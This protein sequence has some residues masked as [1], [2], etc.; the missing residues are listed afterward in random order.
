ML[1][2]HHSGSRETRTSRRTTQSTIFKGAIRYT[3]TSKR[4]SYFIWT[5]PTPA[6]PR[7]AS[8]ELLLPRPLVVVAPSSQLRARARTALRSTIM[9]STPAPAAPRGKTRVRHSPVDVMDPLEL[10]RRALSR[11][12]HDWSSA[13]RN[14]VEGP[15]RQPRFEAPSPVS[16]SSH[17]PVPST[18]PGTTSSSS[19]CS[20]SSKWVGRPRGPG[21]PRRQLSSSTR[22]TGSPHSRG[23]RLSTEEPLP[24]ESVLLSPAAAAQLIRECA[25]ISRLADCRDGSDFLIA[26]RLWKDMARGRTHAFAQLRTAALRWQSL[27]SARALSSWMLTTV[28]MHKRQALVHTARRA[29]RY[30]RSKHLARGL[31]TLAERIRSRRSALASLGLAVSR[32]QRGASYSAMAYWT[33][34]A[35]ESM[36]RRRRSLAAASTKRHRDQ[37]TAWCTWHGVARRRAVAWSRLRSAA[38]HMRHLGSARAWHQWV[39]RRDEAWASKQRASI[40]ARTLTLRVWL[41]WTDVTDATRRLLSAMR[42]MRNLEAAKAWLTWTDV[43]DATRRLLSAMRRMRNLEAAKAWLTWTDASFRAAAVRRVSLRVWRWAMQRALTTWMHARQLSRAQRHSGT[44]LGS[45]V[46]GGSSTASSSVATTA[47]Q[48]AVLS[49]ARRFCKRLR[50]RDLARG[51][52]AWRRAAAE[53]RAAEAPPLQRALL[54]CVRCGAP[55]GAQPQVRL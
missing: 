33:A 24:G 1:S 41:T 32:W 19:Y 21:A 9:R 6:G 44:M 23:G 36:G 42:R 27:A 39:T 2:V 34:V 43:T 47:T 29:T 8:G 12:V 11:G 10:A 17:S 46:S 51:W 55:D 7:R 4:L 40:A 22:A 37:L 13:G 18:S 48:R 38:C 28:A 26:W 20:T 5:E 16:S 31:A 53:G 25:V 14:I 49:M 30:T 45:M 3:S 15:L 35:V 50:G 52:S 54:A